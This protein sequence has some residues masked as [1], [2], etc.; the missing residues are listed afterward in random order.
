[1]TILHISMRYELNP[2]KTV[3]R[4]RKIAKETTKIKEVTAIFDRGGKDYKLQQMTFLLMA[5]PDIPMR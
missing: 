2:M 4:F 3:G 1:M 5:I